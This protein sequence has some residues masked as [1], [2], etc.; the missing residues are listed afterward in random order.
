MLEIRDLR[1]MFAPEQVNKIGLTCARY[2]S[3]PKVASFKEELFHILRSKKPIYLANYALRLDGVNTNLSE[4]D[5]WNILEE[6]SSFTPRILDII[7]DH[8][9]KRLSVS[10]A[11]RE[12]LK[13]LGFEFQNDSSLPKINWITNKTGE[14]IYRFAQAP[15]EKTI[16]IVRTIWP[17]KED[18]ASTITENLVCAP[19]EEEFNTYWQT[20]I[21]TEQP[22]MAI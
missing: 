3:E 5:K 10:Y 16:F 8:E 2:L 21:K 15:E 4:K 7:D 1:A 11:R 9:I 22:L 17:G 20:F 14:F 12:M 18:Y 19:T 13:I 6:Q